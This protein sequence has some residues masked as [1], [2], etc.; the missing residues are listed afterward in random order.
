MGSLQVD[1]NEYLINSYPVT[2]P[3]EFK[4]N[5]QIYTMQQSKQQKTNLVGVE[6]KFWI[7]RWSQRGDSEGKTMCYRVLHSSPF[8]LVFSLSL[9]KEGIQ[10]VGNG[11]T[12]CFQKWFI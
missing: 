6:N 8:Y 5:C 12:I 11:K 2:F 9:S 10:G 4:V 1:L 3:K 7:I